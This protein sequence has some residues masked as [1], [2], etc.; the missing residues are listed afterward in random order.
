MS[1]G[2]TS[3]KGRMSDWW[4]LHCSQW[5]M[6]FSI[7]KFFHAKSIYGVFLQPQTKALSQIVI[8]RSVVTM[9]PSKSKVQW[10]VQ[11]CFVGIS[12]LTKGSFCCC[13]R[14]LS[15]EGWCW[16]LLLLVHKLSHSFICLL[17]HVMV[18][19]GIWS[20]LFPGFKECPAVLWVWL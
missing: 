12:I 18:S 4:M 1:V 17:C 9:L 2:P 13:A 3:T 10:W 14:T 6:V 15:F 16:L 11:K 7:V 8:L 20:C 19:L 5:C